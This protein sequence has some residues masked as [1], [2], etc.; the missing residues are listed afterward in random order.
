[1]PPPDRMVH[2]F[3]AATGGILVYQ[4]TISLDESVELLPGAGQT[5]A[6]GGRGEVKYPA[7]FRPVELLYL[8]QD[9]GDALL[10]PQALEHGVGTTQ[11]GL[12]HEETLLPGIGGRADLVREALPQLFGVSRKRLLLA[13]E[14]LVVVDQGIGGDAV[15][16]G[17]E[18][19]LVAVAAQLGDHPDQNLLGG[20]AGFARVPEHADGQGVNPVLNGLNDAFQGLAVASHSGFDLVFEGNGIAHRGTVRV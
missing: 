19:T 20:I 9:I 13:L 16:P 5:L 18:L 14:A 8:A 7:R 6:E 1:M 17:P 11:F 10:L 2:L 15:D 12:G 3:V 4:T